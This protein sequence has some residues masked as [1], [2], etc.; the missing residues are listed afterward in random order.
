MHGLRRLQ[1]D[2][3]KLAQIRYRLD[4]MPCTGVTEMAHRARW[5]PDQAGEDAGVEAR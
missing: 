1:A 5:A 3:R 2:G 4:R